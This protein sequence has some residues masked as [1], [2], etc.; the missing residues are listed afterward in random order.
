MSLN[1][2]MKLIKLRSVNVTDTGTVHSTDPHM[3][4]IIGLQ[5]ANVTMPAAVTIHPPA[6][7]YLPIAG[8]DAA[9]WAERVLVWHKLRKEWVDYWRL[10]AGAYE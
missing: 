3:P 9:L 1:T 10:Q 6:R 5:L 4:V 8:M 2:S 7:A